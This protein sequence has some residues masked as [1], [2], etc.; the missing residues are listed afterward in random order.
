M[1]EALQKKKVPETIRFAT[2]RFRSA[3]LYTNSATPLQKRIAEDLLSTVH[4]QTG[5]TCLKY[6]YFMGA[7]ITVERLS[8]DIDWGKVQDIVHIVLEKYYE[9]VTILQTN[10][11]TKN[12]A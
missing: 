1:L 4:P 5:R 8:S 7:D 3:Q 9:Q 2:G 6:V 11:L 12:V 10:T